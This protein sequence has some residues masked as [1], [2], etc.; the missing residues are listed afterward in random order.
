MKEKGGNV[1]GNNQGSK[2]NLDRKSQVNRHI[3][4]QFC[5]VF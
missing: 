4:I 5:L 3:E 1:N 2:N